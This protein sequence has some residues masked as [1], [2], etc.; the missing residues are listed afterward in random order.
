MRAEDPRRGV[1]PA[2]AA[3]LVIGELRRSKGQRRAERR[4]KLAV[5]IA[6]GE[7]FHPIDLSIDRVRRSE[8][9][10]R[11]RDVAERS[12]HA[13]TARTPRYGAA[14]RHAEL[15]AAAGAVDDLLRSQ[16]RYT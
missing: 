6:S 11:S 13:S 14:S 7:R 4:A 16:G 5:A 2:P 15:D 9:A 1:A 3:V 12:R 8:L 10:E